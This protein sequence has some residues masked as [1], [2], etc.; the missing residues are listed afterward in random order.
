MSDTAELGAIHWVPL[1]KGTHDADEFQAAQAIY[2]EIAKA[3][4]LDPEQLGALAAITSLVPRE[5]QAKGIT[6]DDRYE[7]VEVGL[8]YEGALAVRQHNHS[9]SRILLSNTKRW[10]EERRE[11][12]KEEAPEL[13]T[14]QDHPD[15]V[16]ELWAHVETVFGAFVAGFRGRKSLPLEIRK[17]NEAEVKKAT[18]YLC[19]MGLIECIRLAQ[20]AL[21]IQRVPLG[22]RFPTADPS[23]VQS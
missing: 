6:A 22:D 10:V 19:S 7:G 11:F 4:I 14:A 3:K 5:G 1:Y 18:T 23:D 16:P 21:G 9:F 20:E 12:S 13:W 17:D 8:R 2:D 15:T